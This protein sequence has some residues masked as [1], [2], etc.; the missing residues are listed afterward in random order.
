MPIRYVG[1]EPFF[2]GKTL[3]EIA[4]NLKNLGVGRVVARNNLMRYPEKSFYRLTKVVPDMTD[5][6]SEIP[7]LLSKLTV[8][9]WL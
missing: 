9:W 2:R 3:N 4:R 6:V 8:L 7:R 1:R 5:T